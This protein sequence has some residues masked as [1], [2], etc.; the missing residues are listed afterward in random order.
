M[1]N[2]PIIDINVLSKLEK[3]RTIDLSNVSYQNLTCLE[4]CTNLEIFESSNTTV[5]KISQ[6]NNCLNLK[7]IYLIRCNLTDIDDLKKL[8]KN[9]KIELYL[10]N[11][12]IQGVSDNLWIRV[13]PDKLCA[14]L[15]AYFTGLEN[16][17]EDLYEAKMLFLGD[18]AVG[19]SSLRQR[20]EFPK[21]KRLQKEDATLDINF[22]I[23]NFDC[24][25]GNK[26]K[27]NLF[28]F[29]GDMKLLP[30]HKYFLADSHC[31]YVLLIDERKHEELGSEFYHW[32]PMV[33]AY[34]GADAPIVVIFNNKEAN[35]KDLRNYAIPDEIK[36]E[37][38]IVE[39]VSTN[40]KTKNNW[41]AAENMLKTVLKDTV[42][43]QKVAWRSLRDKIADAENKNY[44]DFS[45][46]SEW[47]KELA[48]NIEDSI[49]AQLLHNLGYCFHFKQSPT[50]KDYVFTNKNWLVKA[51]YAIL[52]D[53]DTEKQRKSFT[54]SYLYVLLQ[55]KYKEQ[56]YK[57][58]DCQLIL[59]CMSHFK[60]AYPTEQ[61]NDKGDVVYI[62]SSELSGE[63]PAAYKTIVD[64][65]I[66]DRSLKMQF[67]FIGFMPFNLVFALMAT[68]Y[69]KIHKISIGELMQWRGGVIFNFGTDA[70][71]EFVEVNE[72]RTDKIKAINI[73]VV[74]SNSFNVVIEDFKKIFNRV[75]RHLDTLEIEELL[76]CNC[77]DC[78]KSDKPTY[79]KRQEDLLDAIE[80]NEETVLCKIT[81]PWKRINIVTLLHGYDIKT[82]LTKVLEVA[83]EVQKTGLNTNRALHSLNKKFEGYLTDFLY[84]KKQIANENENVS[85]LYELL[86][87]WGVDIDDMKDCRIAIA[88][89]L[90]LS[91]TRNLIYPNSLD[92]LAMG[93]S[94]YK[95][96][97]ERS[98]YNKIDFSAAILQYCRAVE[99]EVKEIFE[100][101]AKSTYAV[102]TAGNDFCR[103]I[104]EIKTPPTLPNK[105]KYYS[106]GNQISDLEKVVINIDTST[107]LYVEF[108]NFLQATYTNAF[109]KF[110][111]FVKGLVILKTDDYR[112]KAAHPATLTS[113]DANDCKNKVIA[114]LNNLL[115][116]K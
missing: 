71:P 109:G 92:F 93:W 5:G 75:E 21:R 9:H 14:V 66:T 31:V 35:E 59:D 39:A 115:D 24:G 55:E 68:H 27:T 95:K 97:K 114:L 85:K 29:G 84:V 56:N 74:G 17:E 94:L 19:K 81:K 11:S 53:T 10:H 111:A 23:W 86:D 32:L 110:T 64:E 46:F 60:I 62:T 98:R 108:Q 99:G 80:Q 83:Q 33:R 30:V 106:F 1:G 70:N 101:F 73:Q 63:K 38:N 52:W 41:E 44:V 116:A 58:S 61:Q 113:I 88:Q 67:K 47:C 77:V 22:A 87:K 25:N 43:K 26:F 91:I 65:V 16:A 54:K 45:E 69:K 40:L 90:K 7:S 100:A 12:K 48:P 89:E 37:F 105:P 8:V 76:P 2:N 13:L 34:S 20:L 6:L 36:K 72:Q 4:K 57:L 3:L 104:R 42:S 28:D 79:F 50:L 107:A 82:Q 102:T 18:K 78:R 15:D 112:N 96:F 51:V 49:L 103:F